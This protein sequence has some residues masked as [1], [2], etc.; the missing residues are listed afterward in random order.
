MGGC[1]GI[2]PFREPMGFSPRRPAANASMLLRTCKTKN[3]KRHAI[4]TFSSVLFLFLLQSSTS[5]TTNNGVS[6]WQ[7]SGHC[8]GLIRGD[9]VM[10]DLESSRS[11]DLDCITCRYSRLLRQPFRLSRDALRTKGI[12]E[13]F[14]W[15][16]STRRQLSS[17]P[18]TTFSSQS[19]CLREGV[20][21]SHGIPHVAHRLVEE[22]LLLNDG[23]V[24][25]PVLALGEV[26]VDLK[27]L[28]TPPPHVKRLCSLGET[29]HIPPF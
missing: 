23:H 21:V 25:C 4:L 27:F 26:L 18:V 12:K 16:P 17:L 2:S 9:K 13:V 5:D 1:A 10:Q 3:M 7:V 28:V 22:L 20:I 19:V 29:V 11:R 14:P 8:T 24:R 6:N 15:I